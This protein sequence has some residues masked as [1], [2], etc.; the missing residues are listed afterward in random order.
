[1]T[2]RLQQ[3]AHNYHNLDLKIFL[4]FV[5][6][7]FLHSLAQIIT[8]ISGSNESICFPFEINNLELK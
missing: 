7:F 3:L 6:N 4:N 2:C 1:M 8:E 5:L